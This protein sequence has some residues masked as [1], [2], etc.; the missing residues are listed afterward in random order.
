VSRQLLV[1]RGDRQGTRQVDLAPPGAAPVVVGGPAPLLIGGPCSVESEEQAM[2]IARRIAA[3]GGR[4]FRA[5][6]WKPRTSPYSFQGLGQRGLEILRVVHQ[7]TGLLICTE[8]I[9]GECLDAVAGVAHVVQI[10]SRNMDNSSLLKRAGKL[11]LPVLLKR[12]FAAT[13]EELLL[14][15]EYLL[16]GGNQRVV[17]CERGIRTFGD[18]SRNTLDLHAVLRLRPRTDLPV[19]VDPSHAAGLREDVVPL[20]R[21]ALA[22]GADGLIVEV[23][24]RPA[25]ALSDGAQAIS[26]EEFEL[27]QGEAGAVRRWARG[28]ASPS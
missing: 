3:A 15:A 23:H 9:D 12:G 26:P 13:L 18:H 2:R 20:A 21:A 5:G 1:E 8:A 4:V 16:A 25:E 14:A 7:E 24:D 11:Q 19:I 10:G 6:A 28:G 27:L 22:V 17:L